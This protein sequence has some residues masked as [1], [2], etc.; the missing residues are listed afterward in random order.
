ML[1]TLSADS[2]ADYQNH[3]VTLFS[4]YISD[5]FSISKNTWKI[6]IKLWH[7]DLSRT[8]ELLE[9]TF[10]KYG[11]PP[12]L[13]SNMLRS[14]LL[15]ILLKVSSIT[16]WV[17]LLKN[18]PLYTIISG[19]EPGDVPGIGTFY[20]FF[21]R[22][23]NSDS[24]NLSPKERYKKQ[25]TP[26][27]KKHGEK[28]PNIKDTTAYKLIRY[29]KSHHQE[30]PDKHPVGLIFRL[31]K[32]QFLDVSVKKGLI[33]PSRLS[34]AGDGTPIRTQARIR[35]QKICDCY[36][37]HGI[38]HCN[39]KRKFSQP[40]CN[41][42]WD[43][44]RDCYFNG[45]HL[46]MYVASDSDNDL[47][48][49]PLLERASRHDMLS[50]LHSFFKM[51][52]WMPEFNVTKILLDAAHDADAVY[53]YFLKEGITPFIDL[54]KGNTGKRIYMDTFTV[55]A[56]GVP[57]CRKG[58]KMHSYG[59]EPDRNRHKWRCPLAGKD[60]CKC[61]E[62]CS[63][64]AYGRVVYTKTKDNPRIF[65]TPA[66]DTKAWKDEYAKRTSVERSNKREK[67]DYQLENGRH[68]S[69]KMWYCRLYAIMMCQHLDAWEVPDTDNFQS[70][71]LDL[72]V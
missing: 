32:E 55:N 27:G 59:S 12:R 48:V 8:D 36:K 39:C 58:L 64:S 35:Y 52:R 67:E 56:D 25:K 50:F 10:S 71:T 40:D 47:P 5:P 45:Y 38:L 60:G 70:E 16:K 11:P 28:T 72:T 21:G 22:C 4:Q 6:I 66:R 41:I 14:Y 9:D 31:Y 2:H 51:R 65:N 62:P 68:R 46:Y 61:D 18:C 30:N 15:S 57:V 26:K 34:V 43:S 7:L 23:W 53:R 33:N 44:S 49:F 24:N 19:F 37:K 63:D 42:G 54:N 17:E 13:P 29:F 3:F 69:T 20:D 1:L